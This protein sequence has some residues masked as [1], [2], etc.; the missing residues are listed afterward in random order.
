MDYNNPVVG[1]VQV[2][3]GSLEGGEKEKPRR[4]SVG[5]IE[6]FSVPQEE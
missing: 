3:D 4:T 6:L 2:E 1:V 5:R